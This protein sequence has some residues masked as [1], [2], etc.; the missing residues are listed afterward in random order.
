MGI[1]SLT[2]LYGK[3][4]ILLDV[5]STRSTLGSV[6]KEVEKRFGL[7]ENGVRLLFNGKTMSDVATLESAG[8]KSNAKLMA[9]RT[10]TQHK[11]EK[12]FE[13]RRKLSPVVENPA[14]LEAEPSK[15][16]SMTGSAIS[17]RPKIGDAEIPGEPFIIVQKGRDKFRINISTSA[18]VHEVKLRF[19]SLDGVE[20][21]ACEV[22]LMSGG[23][24]LKDE[25]TLNDYGVKEGATMMALFTARHHDRQE[26]RSEMVK[27]ADRV[28][29]LEREMSALNRSVEHRLATTDEIIVIRS[30]LL[31][32]VELVR[33]NVSAVRGEEDKAKTLL[34]RLDALDDQSAKQ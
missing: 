5:P 14:R 4:Q 1:I 17:T 23:K 13:K 10:M 9:M 26:A 15:S 33:S 29:R 3:T 8:I 21:V 27:L 20:A 32:D 16:K 12:E 30:Q 34:K 6:R 31:R 7:V 24:F 2:V 25:M 19:A 18:T 22:R 28:E 11:A